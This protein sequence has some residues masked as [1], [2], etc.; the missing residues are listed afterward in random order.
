M[1]TVKIPLAQKLAFIL[2][3]NKLNK[4]KKEKKICKISF[5][6]SSFMKK[7]IENMKSN[8]EIIPTYCIRLEDKTI[9]SDELNIDN[10]YEYLVLDYLFEISSKGSN[11]IS[12]IW[13]NRL[14]DHRNLIF[15][16]IVNL[17]KTFKW[18]S[19]YENYELH[20]RIDKMWFKKNRLMYYLLSKD[21][22][23]V[24]TKRIVSFFNKFD[25]MNGIVFHIEN[26]IKR[27]LKVALQE[28]IEINE[29]NIRVKIA[30]K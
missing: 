12:R 30:M 3:K 27:L 7:V 13:G 10:I 14:F 21:N 11:D 28:V 18:Y 24:Y 2:R 26:T 8:I 23:Q 16:A 4:D 17:L 29:T 20:L 1:S 6:W 25:D 19:D 15:F 9:F 22:N 5:S